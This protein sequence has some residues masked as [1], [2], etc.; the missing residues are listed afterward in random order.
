[1]D[2]K[3][4][5][6]KHTLGE[7][8]DEFSNDLGGPNRPSGGGRS[9]AFREFKPLRG[10]AAFDAPRGA[11]VFEPLAGTQ[12][13]VSAPDLFVCPYGD[14][15]PWRRPSKGTPIPTCPVHNVTFVPVEK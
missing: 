2:S 1:M 5:L 12:S 15:K 9:D 13:A 4:D 3:D 7:D 10:D 8:L 11:P 6:R 14:Q